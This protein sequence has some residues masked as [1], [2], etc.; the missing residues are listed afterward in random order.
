MAQNS[1]SGLH[2]AGSHTCCFSILRMPISATVAGCCSSPHLF[3]AD[4]LQGKREICLCLISLSRHLP[5]QGATAN[6]WIIIH[7]I[8]TPFKTLG[9]TW[10]PIPRLFIQASVNKRKEPMI[11]LGMQYYVWLCW[12]KKKKR[13]ENSLTNLIAVLWVRRQTSIQGWRLSGKTML[14]Q[15]QP[16]W[17][18]ALGPAFLR[19]ISGQI[20]LPLY[21]SPTSLKVWVRWSLFS[22]CEG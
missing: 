21:A 15:G 2:G 11:L 14:D 1:L 16:G 9:L 3:P 12:Q 13:E 17:S 5:P 19:C 20:T 4:F 8:S 7:L 10:L 18:L 22:L 6:S